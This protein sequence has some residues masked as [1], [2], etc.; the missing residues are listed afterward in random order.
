MAREFID[1]VWRTMGINVM[2]FAAHE[3]GDDKVGMTM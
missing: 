1:T 3:K 2:M